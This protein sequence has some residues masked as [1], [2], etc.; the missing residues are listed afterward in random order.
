[1]SRADNGRPALDRAASSL[2]RTTNYVLSIF[3]GIVSVTGFIAFAADSSVK[4]FV[5]HHA[6]SIYIALLLTVLVLLPTLNYTL[7]LRAKNFQ[8]RTALH[9]VKAT[10]A[11]GHDAR[12]FAE[13]LSAV[14]A[15]G[16]VL[17]WL[18]RT[19]LTT[20]RPAD[21]PAD[22]LSSLEKT[23]SFPG[24]WPVGFDNDDMTTAMDTLLSTIREFLAAVENWTICLH[25]AHPQAVAPSQSPTAPDAVLSALISSRDALLNAYDAFITT[26]HAQGIDCGLEPVPASRYLQ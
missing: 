8:L 20:L 11:I 16:P 19:Q 23:T 1:M 4:R 25:D 21:V 22:V 3:T 18:R 14:P 6:S 12:L 13:L 17:A 10:H 24:M 15:T 9:H 7:A 5:D 2:I 26:A